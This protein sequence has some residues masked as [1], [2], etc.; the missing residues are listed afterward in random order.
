MNNIYNNIEDIIGNTPLLKADKL[1]LELGL[2][3]DIYAKLEYF[4]PTGS[5]KDRA[6]LG[7]IISAERQGLLKKGGTI[8]EPTSGNTGIALAAI[9]ASRGYRAIIVMPSSMSRERQLFIKAYG[10][11][12]VLTEAALGMIGAIKR[13]DELHKE[14]ENSFIPSQFDNIANKNAHFD[15]TGPEIYNSL[16]G[17]VDVFIAAVGTGGTISGVGEYLKSKNGNTRIIAVEPK[18]SP[19]LSGGSAAPHKIQGIGAN[20]IPDL[21][22]REIYDE[23]ITVSAD[24]AYETVRMASR[25]LGLG[26]GISSGAALSAAISVARRA[27]MKGKSIAVLLPDGIDRYLSTDIFD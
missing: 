27:D 10:A 14:I 21:L 19:L 12:V 2:S 5:A 26:I 17:N 22:N 25:I 11:E 3:A 1:K 15:T 4:N 23:V 7:M 24:E 9:A 8:I 13:A 16:D 6:A 18:E 20:F